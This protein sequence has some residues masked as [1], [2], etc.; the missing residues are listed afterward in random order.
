MEYLSDMLNVI[1]PND[2]NLNNIHKNH[3]YSS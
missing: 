3:E 2:I 1:N